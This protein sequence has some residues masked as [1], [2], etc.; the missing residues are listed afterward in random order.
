[1][2]ILRAIALA[3]PTFLG[4][5]GAG[6]IHMIIWTWIGSW[7]FGLMKFIHRSM[8]RFER[9]WNDLLPK[10]YEGD[11]ALAVYACE[12]SPGVL[13]VWNCLTVIHHGVTG[14]LMLIGFMTGWASLWRH[15]MLAQVAGM[16][17]LEFVKMIHCAILPP[18]PFPL[19]NAMR[20]KTYAPLV[21]F[22][23]TVSVLVGVPVNLYFSHLPEFQWFGAVIAGGPLFGL[24]PDLLSRVIA[25]FS[26]KAI[27]FWC[28]FVFTYQRLVFYFPRTCALLKI[29]CA[30]EAVPLSIKGGFM[31]GAF[32][33]SVYNLLVFALIASS[34]LQGLRRDAESTTLP[35]GNAMN[36][37]VGKLSPKK[38]VDRYRSMPA[39][40]RP[41]L[42][43]VDIRSR[44]EK[45]IMK[46]KSDTVFSLLS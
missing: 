15:G 13:F 21:L 12:D 36:I 18:G 23:H 10:K 42:P 14:G 43:R 11:P 27:H 24:V 41:L 26:K 4:Q 20:S 31:I 22:H 7:E 46:S 8:Q 2:E 3:E 28:F 9:L 32:N 16:D 6:V 19:C 35:D 45:T 29:V 39:L 34:L 30:S 40:R 33:L 37:V 38:C 44:S 5:V 1:M 17:I 25:S